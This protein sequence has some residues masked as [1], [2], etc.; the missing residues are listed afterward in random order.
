MKKTIVM[1]AVLAIF[2][3]C[4]STPSIQTHHKTIPSKKNEYAAIEKES[5][6]SA[7]STIYSPF[8]AAVAATPQTAIVSAPQPVVVIPEVKNFDFNEEKKEK[9][10]SAVSYDSDAQ[11]IG[12][13]L[14]ITGKNAS[15]GQRALN[16]IRLGLGLDDKSN[17]QLAIYDS[18]SNPDL[19]SQG[20][21]KLLRD[22]HV[23]A[24]LGGLSSKEAQNISSKAE[25]FQVPFFSFS[26][27]SG[28][29]TEA[30][31]TFR[32]SVTPEMQVARLLQ[33]AFK[34]LNA[35]RFAILYPNDAYGTEFA[36]KYWDLVLAGGGE[37]VAAQTYDP[38]DTN[39]DIYVKKLVGTYY[40]DARSEEYQARQKEI[41]DKKKKQKELEPNK[42]KNS[43]E[44]ETQENILPPIVDF[45][46]LFV[47]DSGKAL[48]QI[49]AFMKNN[50]VTQMTYLGT[51]LWNTPDL[52]RR[53]G[54]NTSNVFFVDANLSVDDQKKSDFH[55]K[56]VTK[57]EEEPTI[58]EA[59]IY[60]AAKIL[61]DAI[62]SS[63]ISRSSLA[64]QLG[65]LGRKQGAYSEIRMNNNHEIERPLH[66][67]SLTEG[68][69]QK[70]E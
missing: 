58:V 17:F 53:V 57:Y 68:A 19:A 27:K 43:R 59:Q 66:I 34:N 26:Q 39:L 42:K 16:A 24:I 18:Q 29:T 6:Q 63:S 45:D 28:L 50:D 9:P 38:K 30:E 14:P 5:T 2:H 60:E 52:Y 64:Y 15:L 8:P 23:V 13:I 36:N 21:E 11:K 62:G 67:F 35:K 33:H 3:G 25:F 49:M 47:P 54:N 56:Y 20:V 69:I 40:V 51:N 31:Y 61:K 55:S 7:P 46:V 37:V 44:H 65:I 22:D 1:L 32:N 48:G 4:T 41:A 70:T 12:V 10:R